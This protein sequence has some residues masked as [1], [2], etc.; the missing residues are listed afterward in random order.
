MNNKSLILEGGGMRGVYTA[1]VLDY[2]Q[3]HYIEFDQI[4]GVSAGTC[5]GCSYISKQKGR[6][7]KVN[8]D[9]LDDKNYLSWSNLIK[10][11]SIFN[12]NMLFNTIPNE[13]YPIDDK[14]Y[15]NSNTK[16]FATCTNLNTGKAEYFHIKDINSDSKYIEAGCSI[17]GLANIVYI[18]SEPYLDGGIGDSLPIKKAIQDGY[19]KNIVILTRD[20]EYTKD[21]NKM[22][23]ILK[24][25]Y[26]KYPNFVNAIRARHINYNNTLKF[27]KKEEAKG[28]CFVI[29]PSKP[30]NISNLEKNKVVLKDIY[31]LGYNDAK[32]N[33]DSLIMF[34][35]SL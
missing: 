20:I 16:L 26:H 18:N 32:N 21:R 6:A 19:K 1:G 9:Y 24:F 3:E 29:R 5:H 17:P 10:D 23:N 2:L 4:I 8:T 30:L 35:N 14:V 15:N 28:N 27:I 31:D 7:Y 12:M 22:M 33:Y 11:G 34:I 13:L 25:K